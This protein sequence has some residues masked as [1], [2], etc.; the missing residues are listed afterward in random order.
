MR[1]HPIGVCVIALMVAAATNACTQAPED[2]APSSDPASDAQDAQPALAMPDETSPD[3]AAVQACL[4]R[5]TGPAPPNEFPPVDA[6][7]QYAN[8]D[9]C[10]GCSTGWWYTAEPATLYAAP[11]FDAEPI[12]SVPAGTWLYASET[13]SFTVP[14]KGIVVKSG[15]P[16]SQCDSALPC[17][18]QL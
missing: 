17:L 14:T 4:Q 3:D 12:L 16:F 13:V 6:K 5:Q 9:E 1:F 8:K 7:G 10:R 2:A 15:G 18:Y 11:G